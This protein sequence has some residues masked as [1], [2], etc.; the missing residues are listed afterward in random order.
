MPTASACPILPQSHR[1]FPPFCRAQY[2]ITSPGNAVN[3]TTVLRMTNLLD[4]N[5][6]D[7]RIIDGEPHTN[8]ITT[9]GSPTDGDYIGKF[10]QSAT[11]PARRIA[12]GSDL[13]PVLKLLCAGELGFGAV[14]VYYVN[15]QIQYDTDVFS[16]KDQ[17]T[18]P[19]ASG[20]AKTACG[21]LFK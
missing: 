9:W 13:I 7:Y 4:G 15:G 11:W 3:A 6:T 19:K 20:N 14:G 1:V 18:T 2:S 17:L 21:K 10:A 8:S 12:Y 5:K 16:T